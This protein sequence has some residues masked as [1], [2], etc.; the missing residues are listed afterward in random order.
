MLSR[1]QISQFYTNGIYNVKSYLWSVPKVKWKHFTFG[2]G[3][4][5]NHGCDV[6]Q[7]P[8]SQTGCK[9]T[10]ITP[11]TQAV[12]VLISKKIQYLIR[13]KDTIQ[14]IWEISLLLYT[15][16]K[17]QTHF[18]SYQSK[19]TMKYFIYHSKTQ[20]W[21]SSSQPKSRLQKWLPKNCDTDLQALEFISN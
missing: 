11:F 20:K 15:V 13:Q 4:H 12:H 17:Q 14:L 3:Q 5:H 18:I 10:I 9:R 19:F 1:W 7:Y 8:L 16:L 6:L 2:I 21:L